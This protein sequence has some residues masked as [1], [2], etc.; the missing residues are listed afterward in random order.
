ME[1]KGSRHDSD[2]RDLSFCTFDKKQKREAYERQKG[3]CAGCSKHFEL[4]E[5]EGDYITPWR[6]GD[7][8]QWSLDLL[9]HFSITTIAQLMFFICKM[10]IHLSF[11]CCIQDTFQ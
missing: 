7:F 1:H 11:Q 8:S 3:I 5:M 10:S 6:E 4:E 9:L 2:E